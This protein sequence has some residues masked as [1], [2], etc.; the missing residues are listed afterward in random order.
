MA[1]RIRDVAERAGVSKTT[2]SRVL[3]KARFVDSETRRRVL[4]SAR[5]LNY[6][7][8]AHAQRLARGRSDFFGLIISDI[9]NPVFPEMI[10]SF[11][12]AAAEKGYDLLLCTTNYDPDRTQ[13]VVRKM[14]ENRVRGVAV[15][16]SGASEEVAEELAARQV[17]VVFL[18]LGLTK[19]YISSIRIDY[20][21]GIC[22]AV[23]LL[24]NLGHKKFAFVAGREA[25]RSARKYREAVIQA[26]ADRGL[27]SQ[28]TVEG[29]QT[30]EGGIAAA[31][32]ILAQPDLPTAILCINDLTAIGV[33]SGLREAGWRVPE[34]MS[35]IGC[36]DIYLA[37]F[38][39]PPLTSVRLDRKR[40]GQLA[41]EVLEAMFRSRQRKGT[42]S[43]LETQLIVR[44]STAPCPTGNV[45]RPNSQSIV[46]Q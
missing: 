41:Y 12:T 34:E 19:K 25:R 7:R 1:C 35:V 16:T 15:M 30:L 17:A 39:H 28:L 14:I 18:D 26:L 4:E 29:D 31:R 13:A 23:D 22:Q 9:E 8:N 46:V 43:V 36:E 40:L 44:Q 3:N 32:M 37:R 5:Q 2:V 10:K 27:P 38:V 11:E 21:V 42:E 24:L 33:M 45:P 6:Y 20:S